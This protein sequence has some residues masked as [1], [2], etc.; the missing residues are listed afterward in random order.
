MTSVGPARP[1]ELLPA[2]RWLLADRSAA[3][4]DRGAERGYRYLLGPAAATAVV[5]VARDAR[6]RVSG[7][8]VVQILPGATGVT[9]PP[10]AANPAAA[11][12][13]A[14][15]ATD[16][17][18]SRGA[19]VAQAFP[20]PADQVA[21][22]PLWAAGF[23]PVTRVLFLDR[24]LGPSPPLRA[25]LSFARVS[26]PFAEPLRSVL[27]AT[28][29]ASRDCPELTAARTADE[30]L[31]GFTDPDRPVAW[32][33]ASDSGGPRGVVALAEGDEPTT[34]ELFYLGLVPASRGQGYGAALLGFAIGAA[35]GRGAGRLVVSV[36]ERNEP[37]V[38]LY[39]RAG[40]VVTGSRAVWLAFLGSGPGG[41]PGDP[42]IPPT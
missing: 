30:L 27:L 6:G 37:A 24:P 41:G 23:H 42:I 19:K 1:D 32:Y 8:T 15:A 25:D 22:E 4:R 2:L 35:A 18:W 20:D 9:W 21:P 16:W 11:A 17:L 33:L 26:S 29:D 12:A 34:A 13:L 10:R 3:E 39:R 40:F 28:H 5:L 14:R 36:D 31:T 7:A 38:R